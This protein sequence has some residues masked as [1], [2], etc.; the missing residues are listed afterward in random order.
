M[1]AENQCPHCTRVLQPFRVTS[2]AGV[3][4]ELSGCSHCSKVWAAGGH[5]QRSFGV[6]ALH[7]LVGGTT[8]HSCVECRILLTPAH[9]GSGATVEVCSAC[10]GLLIDETDLAALGIRHG[11]TPPVRQRKVEPAVVVELEEDEATPPP[12]LPVPRRTVASAEPVEA[13][14]TF[15]CVLCEQRKPLREGQAL[16]DGLACRTCMEARARG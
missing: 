2:P 9:L 4:V 10:H 12:P 7:H 15:V 1:K 14:G 16:R 6:K 13:P 5:L 11:V 3:E 8:Q